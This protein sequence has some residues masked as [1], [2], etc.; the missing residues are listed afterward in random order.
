MGMESCGLK[1]TIEYCSENT[2]G[3]QTVGKC[4]IWT[5]HTFSHENLEAGND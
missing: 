1:E 2:E 3:M 5:N 4:G